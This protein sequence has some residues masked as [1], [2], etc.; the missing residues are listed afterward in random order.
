[1]FTGIIEEVGTVAELSTD[2]SGGRLRV[3]CAK[4][5]PR[6]GV[7]SSVAVSGCCLTIV[8]QDEGSFWCDLAPETLNRTSFRRLRA[9]SEVNLEV[10]L[11]PATPLGGHIVQGHVDGTG[12]LA[13]LPAAGDGNYWLDVDVPAELGRT[14]VEQGSVAVEGISLTVAAIEGTRLRVAIIPFT[15]ENTNLR[16]LQP[17]DPVNLECD[18]LAKYVEKLLTERPGAARR[19]AAAS[20]LTL[21]RLRE[22]GF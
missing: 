15:Y 17:G 4:L 9:G 11:T 21:D 18:V 16:S 7:S 20:R 8:R 3:A 14:L 2:S 12:T 1:M 10:P 22:E 19:P 5:L 13:G 6:L